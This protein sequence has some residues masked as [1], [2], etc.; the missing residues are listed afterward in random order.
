MRRRL[1]R[2]GSYLEDRFPDALELIGD[3][4]GFFLPDDGGWFS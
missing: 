4:I 1:A 2:I 3:I